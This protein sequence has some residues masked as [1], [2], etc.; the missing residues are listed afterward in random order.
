MG[1]QANPRLLREAVVGPRNRPT[2]IGLLPKK[3]GLETF[4]EVSEL[5]GGIG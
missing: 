5:L 1:Q 2:G 3:A 4:R